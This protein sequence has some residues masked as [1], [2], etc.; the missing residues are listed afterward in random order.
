[1]CAH[2]TAAGGACARD[3]GIPPAAPHTP[4]RFEEDQAFAQYQE[5]QIRSLTLL[6]GAWYVRVL[7][8]YA[9]RVSGRIY[10]ATDESAPQQLAVEVRG[11]RAGARGAGRA[12]G[13][14][15]GVR[16]EGAWR[17]RAG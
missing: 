9:G 12:P 5:T 8:D 17:R 7:G 2:C 6:P 10:D 15:G 14:G 3:T 13:P 4:T 11:A 1:M 16:R